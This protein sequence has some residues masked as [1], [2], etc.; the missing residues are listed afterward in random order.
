M[1]AAESTPLWTEKIRIRSYD[2]DLK[3][4]ASP[5]ALCRYFLEAAWNHAEE[6]GFGFSHLAQQ[7]R[8]WVLARLVI[9]IT[10]RPQWGDEVLLKTWPR[11]ARSIL[12]LRDFEILDAG[13]NQLLGGSS[14]W[15]VLD[16]A[17]RRPQRLDGLLCDTNA[18]SQRMAIQNDPAKL[19]AG[20]DLAEAMVVDSK[21][22]DMDVN[23]HVN[24]AR[25]IGWVLDSFPIDFHLRHELRQVEVNYVG[26]TTGNAR[27][28]VRSAEQTPGHW[29]HAILKADGDEACRART[30]WVVR[31]GMVMN[32]GGS[33]GAGAAQELGAP[34]SGR[35]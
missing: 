18:F 2:V 10:G 11:P 20:T 4:K 15:L 27:L 19:S 22:S 3:K 34:I 5:E 17:S 21:Y 33:S 8:F 28:S 16:S 23:G 24:S 32:S 30:E 12:A 25:Y 31:P 14:A 7:Q 1:P 29:Q 13:G 9:R 6:L 26:E 35:Q